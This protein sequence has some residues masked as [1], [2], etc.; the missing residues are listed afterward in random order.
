[1]FHYNIFR[2]EESI[3]SNIIGTTRDIYTQ[4]DEK[5]C[6]LVEKIGSVMWAVDIA[7]K[8]EAVSTSTPP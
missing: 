1:M 3:P 5:K 8:S 2:T 6:M 4:K 7:P